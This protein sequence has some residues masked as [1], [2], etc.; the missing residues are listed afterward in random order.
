MNEDKPV[1]G[2]L[3]LITIES[4]AKIQREFV[5]DLAM[6]GTTPTPDEIITSLENMIKRLNQTYLGR[7]RAYDPCWEVK[8]QWN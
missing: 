7:D 1:D 8:K 2:Q 6:H 5:A 4:W 3:I